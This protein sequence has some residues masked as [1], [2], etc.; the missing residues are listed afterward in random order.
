M[1]QIICGGHSAFIQA[2]VQLEFEHAFAVFK[3]IHQGV[4]LPVDLD[5]EIIS[6]LYYFDLVP[7]AVMFIKKFQSITSPVLITACCTE[8]RAYTPF[9]AGFPG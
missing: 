7:V 9:T 4:G 2:P 3:Y 6:F 8:R 1:S 5:G